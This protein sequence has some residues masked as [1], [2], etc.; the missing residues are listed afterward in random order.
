[1]KTDALKSTALTKRELVAQIAAE[2]GLTQNDVLTLSSKHSMAASM[3][4]ERAGMR[5][6]EKSG[7]LK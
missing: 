5:S 1:M 2:T 4:S 6:F 3:H 7:S